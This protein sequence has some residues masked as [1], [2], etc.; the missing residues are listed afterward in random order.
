MGGIVDRHGPNYAED[1]AYVYGEIL[2][3]SS[4]Q[5]SDLADHD[6]I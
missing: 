2:G 1:N 5:I 3:Y 4:A 6:I